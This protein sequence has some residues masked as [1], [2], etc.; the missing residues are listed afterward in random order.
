[1]IITCEKCG[2]RFNLDESLL[3]ADGS[4]VRCSRCR[5]IFTAYPPLLEPAFDTLDFDDADF[6]DDEDLTRDDSQESFEFE[7]LELESIEPDEIEI[8]FEEIDTPAEEKLDLSEDPGLEKPGLEEQFHLTEETEHVQKDTG[9]DE[10]FSK[11]SDPFKETTT[12]NDID[13]EGE[14][15]TDEQE[16]DGLDELDDPDSGK[17]DKELTDDSDTSYHAPPPPRRPARASLIQPLDP[18]DELTAH[19]DTLSKK[20]SRVGLPVLIL[21]ILFL[22]TAGGYFAATFFGYKIPFLPEIQ[23]PFIQQYL[24]EKTPESVS[25]PDPIT[26]QKSVTGRFLT[27]DT[28]GELF[29]ITGKIENPAP[30]PYRRIQVKGTLFQKEQKAAMS[31][32]AFC[33]RIIPDET[34]R[35]M[36]V[37]ELTARLTTPR[38]PAENKDQIMPGETAPFMLGFS[39]LPQNLENF[40]VEVAGFEHAAP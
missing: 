9:L 28:A 22:L 4:P 36:P 26:D 32:T 39:D 33:G 11:I 29:I 21:L 23:I 1:M 15:E 14:S 25:H 13:K 7:K 40:T 8:E 2:T 34:L 12:D 10:H 38:E 27:N 37:E 20:R 3:D 19:P 35:T 30:I 6:E 17:T 24:P 18:E 5:N 31:R 16:F